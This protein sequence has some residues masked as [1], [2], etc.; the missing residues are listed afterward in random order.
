MYETISYLSGPS[1]TNFTPLVVDPR[2]QGEEDRRVRVV[3][4]ACYIDKEFESQL[5]YLQ[6]AL[7]DP[8]N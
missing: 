1:E 2:W 5:V 4:P 3:V 7:S 8:F 6:S